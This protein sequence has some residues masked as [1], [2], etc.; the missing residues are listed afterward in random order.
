MITSIQ[1]TNNKPNFKAIIKVN[2][3]IAGKN[4]YKEGKTLTSATKNLINILLKVN[5]KGFET[6]EDSKL[7]QT[8]RAL[9]VKFN[10][11]Q[12]H[13]YHIPSSFKPTIKEALYVSSLKMRFF[14]HEKTKD[15]F[16]LTGN[17]AQILINSGQNIANASKKGEAAL[18][19]A[20]KNYALAVKKLMDKVNS[21]TTS[22]NIF[23]TK[24]GNGLIPEKITVNSHVQTSQIELF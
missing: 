19:A 22:I 15:V 24:K 18:E 9:F 11:S 7:N 17:D 20:K 2:S 6:T 16:I 3:V 21:D 13:H 12:E 8:I 23:A 14:Q 1:N 5:K 4:T 10:T